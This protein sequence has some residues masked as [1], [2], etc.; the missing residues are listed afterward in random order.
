MSDARTALDWLKRRAGRLRALILDP[1]AR[2]EALTRLR[3]G[4]RVHQDVSLSFHDG[5]R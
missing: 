3:Y 4:S 5:W 1:R 2:S